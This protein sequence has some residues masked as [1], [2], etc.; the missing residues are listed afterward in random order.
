[1]G[2]VRLADF[3]RFV[4]EVS[5]VFNAHIVDEGKVG[6]FVVLVS[7][8]IAFVGVRMITHAVRRGGSLFRDVRVAGTHVHHLVPGIVLLLA[9]GYLAFAAGY[10]DR[11]V[12]AALFGIGAALTLDEFAL[13]L[14]LRDVYWERAGKRSVD[15][16]LA[17]AAVGAL[18][19][20]GLDFWEAFLRA[21]ARL[22][23]GE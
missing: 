18:V 7:F 17:A 15:V 3:A 8:L 19:V 4:E 6:A 10:G 12:V 2:V 22:F 16:V 13:W 23:Q 21:S 14:H 1:M 11:P 20:L 9:T 5:E